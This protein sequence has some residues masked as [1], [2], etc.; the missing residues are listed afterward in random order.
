V[1]HVL[2]GFG[3]LHNAE[4]VIMWASETIPHWPAPSCAPR[5]VGQVLHPLLILGKAKLDVE[6][7]LS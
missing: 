5:L 4:V 2:V 6:R 7:S 3:D 1:H